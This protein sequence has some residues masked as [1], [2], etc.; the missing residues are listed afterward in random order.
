N[1]LITRMEDR[2]WIVKQPS[3]TDKRAT[4]ISLTEKAKLNEKPIEEAIIEKIISCNF[5][6]LN[7]ELLMENLKG[8]NAFL[9]KLV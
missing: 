7:A 4:I 9:G 1:P 3:E 8:L 2:G 6:D 5:L